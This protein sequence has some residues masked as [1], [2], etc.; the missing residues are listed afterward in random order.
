MAFEPFYYLGILYTYSFTCLYTLY[1]IIYDLK[2]L[3]AY[4]ILG[5]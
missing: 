3:T 5:M 4:N 1:N 2:Y